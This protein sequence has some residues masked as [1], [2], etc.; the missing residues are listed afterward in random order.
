MEYTKLTKFLLLERIQNTI[1]DH[2]EKMTDEIVDLIV[3]KE[4]K[5]K[6][7]NVIIYH[8]TLSSEMDNI[9]SKSKRDLE[10]KINTLKYL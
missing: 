1:N 5:E 9:F 7:L 10:E 2:Y 4:L 6:N 8:N 3:D